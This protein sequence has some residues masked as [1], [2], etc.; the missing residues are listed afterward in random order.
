[1][2]LVGGQVSQLEEL[3]RSLEQQIHDILFSLPNLPLPDVPQGSTEE[4]NV[5]IRQWGEPRV[6]DFTL[7]IKY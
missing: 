3:V 7:K 2:R 4:D 5:V 1:M 6:F